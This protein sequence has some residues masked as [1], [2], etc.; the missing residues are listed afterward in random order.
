MRERRLATEC[1]GPRHTQRSKYRDCS[2]CGASIFAPTERASCLEI[3]QAAALSRAW[4]GAGS[5]GTEL[6][7][8]VPLFRVLA[9]M[10]QFFGACYVVWRALRTLRPGLGY[11]YSMSF[12]V[13]EA[14]AFLL[15]N[16]FVLSLWSQVRQSISLNDDAST[17]PGGSC[18]SVSCMHRSN[19]G[20]IA[21]QI[22][23]PERLLPSLLPAKQF[24]N[25]DVY[26]ACYS[27]PVEVIEATAIAALNLEYPGD[28]LTVRIL[29]DGKSGEVLAMVNRLQ[30]QLNYM[31][32]DAKILHVTRDK[33]KG[34]PHHA[35]AGNINN[36]LL[37]ASAASAAEF[38]LV[39]DCDMIVH[40]TFLLSTLGHFYVKEGETWV[41]KKL[42]ALL[43]TPQDFW[44]VDAADPMVHCARFFYGPMLQGRDGI[45]ACP[46]CGTGVVFRKDILVSMGGQAY[47]VHHRGLQHRYAGPGGRV[48]NH[49]SPVKWRAHCAGTQRSW[50]HPRCPASIPLSSPRRHLLIPPLLCNC[51]FLNERLVFG[52]SPDDIAGVFQQRLRW[53]MGALQIMIRDNPLKRASQFLLVLPFIPVFASVC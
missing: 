36:C 11:I 51:R 40:P 37:K 29:D 44:N 24:P 14:A 34:V 33:V 2:V 6:K 3:L 38:I 20:L 22:E 39:L 30:K 53:A 49:V 19:V 41:P 50:A 47:W 18:R 43:Q 31:Q 16:A 4:E 35:K 27:E 5:P 13:C 42:A 28:K 10:S 9:G 21:L 52:M 23:R 46:C 12:W 45:G 25:V 32:R 8:T 17:R 48:C 15:G 1:C 26:I 7:A